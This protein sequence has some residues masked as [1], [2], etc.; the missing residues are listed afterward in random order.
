MSDEA[1]VGKITRAYGV[2]F[3]VDD[4]TGFTD[5][6]KDAGCEHIIDVAISYQGKVKEFDLIDFLQRLGF[7]DE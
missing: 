7:Y 5:R 2:F 4:M 1:G 6:M 3:T